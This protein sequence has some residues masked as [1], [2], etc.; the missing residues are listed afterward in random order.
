MLLN[1]EGEIQ[2]DN[3]IYKVTPF[4]TFFADISHEA[5]LNSVYDN[6]YIQND[7]TLR[8]YDLSAPV[9]LSNIDATN[10]AYNDVKLLSKHVYFVDSFIESEV[11]NTNPIN[12]PNDQETLPFIFPLSSFSQTNK[13]EPEANLPLEMRQTNYLTNSSVSSMPNETDPAYQ[14]MAEYKIDFKSGAASIL[15]TVFENSTR[16][17]NFNKNYRVSVLMYNRNYG[18]LK[19]LGIK[20]KF[21]KKGFLWW[22]KTST[23][24]IRGG[25]DYIAYS[26]AISV[27]KISLPNTDNPP[28]TGDPYLINPYENPYYAAPMWGSSQGS[29]G[30]GY[31]LYG[32]HM[33]RGSNELFTVMIPGWLIPFKPDGLEVKSSAFKAAL[34]FGWDKLKAIL[35]KS[36]PPSI[37][38]IINNDPYNYKFPIYELNGGGGK[39]YLSI[40]DM[41]HIPKSFTSNISR[42]DVLKDTKIHTFISPYEQVVYNDD[43]IDIPLDLSTVKITITSD[44]SNIALSATQILKSLLT[45]ELATSFEVKTASIFGAA[46]Y[47]GQW[48]GIRLKVQ[49]D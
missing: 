3:I 4:G 23:T 30:Y 1:E 27:P 43:S 41:E 31:N 45:E 36:A 15:Q 19:T 37:P 14:Q 21:Q 44:P 34:K 28:S 48:L 32:W 40:N 13:Q 10:T 20:V 8:L 38:S 12:F 2:V 46:K 26:S 18:I 25:W 39:K 5:L 17:N 35:V 22:N 6:V 29:N 11:I 42:T 33:K 49:K 47:N 9:S 7:Y 16:Y 24:E